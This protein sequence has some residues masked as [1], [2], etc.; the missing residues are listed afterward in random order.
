MEIHLK[1]EGEKLTSTEP[2]AESMEFFIANI[3]GGV[4]IYQEY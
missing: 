1:F 3:L 2:I 4:A